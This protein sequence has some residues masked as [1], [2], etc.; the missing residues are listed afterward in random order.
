MFD[1]LFSRIP[2]WIVQ[3]H[4]LNDLRLTIEVVEDADVGLLELLPSLMYLH[5]HIEGAPKDRIL[6]REGS[7]LFPVLKRFIFACRMISY[8][9]FE[10]GAM[11]MLETLD[12]YFN[13]HGW[14]KHGAA[15]AGIEHLSGLKEIYVDIGVP[16]SSIHL[17]SLHVN[18]WHSRVIP[19]WIGQLHSLYDLELVVQE[20]P[21]DA[22]GVLARLPSLIHF[23][24]HIYGAP[25]DKI[26]IQGGRVGGG[27]A[28]GWGVVVPA[29]MLPPPAGGVSREE[30]FR[31]GDRGE[32]E[33]GGVAGV[34]AGAG[35][36]SGE[37]RSWGPGE[38]E[39]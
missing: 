11:P 16:D 10:A 19:E 32:G 15:P 18:F 35:V 34:V 2:K 33:G 22:V 4:S 27:G 25:K 9:S 5:L 38:G 21:E 17:Q 37:G 29:E 23:Y 30:W 7:G 24:L 36:A 14:D 3:L 28:G 13:A 12:L 6:I 8:L 31:V 26:H 1:P 20:V 39:R